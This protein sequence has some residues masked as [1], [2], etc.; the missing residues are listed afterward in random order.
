[1]KLEP[2]A[3]AKSAA[4]LL[5]IRDTPEIDNLKDLSANGIILKWILRKRGARAWGF[6]EHSNETS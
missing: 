4:V 2:K 3:T 5:R 1:M 6:Y